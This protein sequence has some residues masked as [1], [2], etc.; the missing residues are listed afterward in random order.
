MDK[1]FAAGFNLYAPGVIGVSVS[2][3]VLI[4]ARVQRK[5]SV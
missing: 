4:C 2:G 5:W 1:Y 3:G